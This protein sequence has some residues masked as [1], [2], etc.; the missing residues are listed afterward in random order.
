MKRQLK[1][2]LC[3]VLASMSVFSS[4]FA[5]SGGTDSNGGHKD[6]KNK[7]GLGSYHYHCGG[8][9]PH[10]HANGMC[11]YSAEYKQ[12]QA[13]TEENN[14]KQTT[15]TSNKKQ[16]VNVAENTDLLP[17]VKALSTYI[18][19][20]LFKTEDIEAIQT[21]LL[22]EFMPFG[23]TEAIL[24]SG[25]TCYGMTNIKGV[26]IRKKESTSSDK[27]CTVSTKGS[28][29]LILENRNNGWFKIMVFEDNKNFT[30][31]VKS[32]TIELI[33]KTEYFLGLCSLL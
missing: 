5:H 25:N 3:I 7:S 29:L 20:Q 30:G 16:Q 28:V 11:P 14:R 22:N 21:L 1:T 15:S 31:Y 26:N 32:N 13:A 27:L 23:L 8:H 18:D 19:K 2:V 9:P 4:A 10:L 12:Q 17:A 6:N 24:N 33:D